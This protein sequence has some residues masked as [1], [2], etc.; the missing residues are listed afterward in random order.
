MWYSHH[1]YPSKLLDPP[2]GLMGPTLHNSNFKQQNPCCVDMHGFI[3]SSEVLIHDLLKPLAK[4][5]ALK[6]LTNIHKVLSFQSKDSNV[7]E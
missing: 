1:G 4:H 2:A 5:K 3:A 7:K 6:V